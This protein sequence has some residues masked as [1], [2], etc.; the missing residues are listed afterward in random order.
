MTFVR[1]PR[2][3]EWGIGRVISEEGGDI[4]VYF[5]GGGPKKLRMPI[6]ALEVVADEEVGPSDLLRHLKPDAEGKFVT[7]PLTFEDMV[8]NFLRIEGGGSEGA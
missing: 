8:G 7:P 4:V 3:L 6:S 2:K 5:E 1:H